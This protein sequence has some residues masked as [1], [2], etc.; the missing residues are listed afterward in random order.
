MVKIEGVFF[1]DK[2]MLVLDKELLNSKFEPTC[3]C[4]RIFKLQDEN[5]RLKAEL[6]ACV[7]VYEEAEEQKEVIRL[8][9]EKV[10]V[11]EIQNRVYAS[12]LEEGNKHDKRA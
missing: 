2:E 12:I 5:E 11:L 7:K 4:E 9:R 10:L 8:L 3:L 6:A 1:R